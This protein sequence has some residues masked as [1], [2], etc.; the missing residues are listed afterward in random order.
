[1][2]SFHG[3]HFLS[4]AIFHAIFIEIEMSQADVHRSS[5]NPATV[6]AF[7]RIR[8]VLGPDLDHESR[9]RYIWVLLKR[10]RIG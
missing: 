4:S 8:R 7:D 9:I 3:G 6:N 1:M 2:S 5:R 10:V